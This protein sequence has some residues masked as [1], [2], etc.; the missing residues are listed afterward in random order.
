M[1]K[2]FVDLAN[3]QLY[4]DLDNA[5]FEDQRKVMEK[6]IEDG[7]CPFCP[8]FLE[9]YHRKPIIKKGKYWT[10]TENQWP[11]DNTRVHL[12]AIFN[13]HVEHL[14]EVP[15]EAG[16]ELFELIE[17][18]EDHYHVKGGGLAMRFGDTNYSAGTVS[19]LHAQFIVPDWDKDDFEPVRVKLGKRKPKAE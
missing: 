15:A 9:R 5:R 6:I 13:I 10:L 17:W 11:Y 19:H 18:A 2:Q 1:K 12:L 7:R 14:R 8:E 3:T 4:V 16:K